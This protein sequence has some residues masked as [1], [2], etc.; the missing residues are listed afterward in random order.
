M[1]KK[2]HNAINMSH[3]SD[4]SLYIFILRL[5]YFFNMLFAQVFKVLQTLDL[6][7]LLFFRNFILLNYHNP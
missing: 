5:A 2:Y 3:S 7:H 6:L 4:I 1:P